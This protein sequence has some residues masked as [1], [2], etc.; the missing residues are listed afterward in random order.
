MSVEL[1]DTFIYNGIRLMMSG[2][3]KFSSKIASYAM[4]WLPRHL[5]T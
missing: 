1:K 2:P 4:R 3:Y 5:Y